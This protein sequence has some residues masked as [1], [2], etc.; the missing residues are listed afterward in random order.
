[1]EKRD[2]FLINKIVSSHANMAEGAIKLIKR[3]IYMQM[4][5]KKLKNWSPLLKD[6][7]M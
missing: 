2:I 4:R 3:R 5:L 6:H 7:V 1:M